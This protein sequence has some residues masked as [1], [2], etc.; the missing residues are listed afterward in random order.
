MYKNMC[1]VFYYLNSS[2]MGINSEK[3]KYDVYR[4]QELVKKNGHTA[5]QLLWYHCELNPV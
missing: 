5:I 4:I 1:P 3:V 2:I